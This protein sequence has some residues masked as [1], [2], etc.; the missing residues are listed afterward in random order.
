MTDFTFTSLPLLALA[1]V[2]MLLLV[3]VILRFSAVL[4][5]RRQSKRCPVPS[6]SDS[7]EL[8]S[9]P[10]SFNHQPDTVLLQ[11]LIGTYDLSSSEVVRAHVQKSLRA[12]GVTPI[13]A[14]PGDPFD[15]G[16]HNGV[17][18]VVAPSP[19]LISRIARVRR[20]GWQSD[21][22]V[23]RPADVEVYKDETI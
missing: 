5:I 6:G 2:T 17:A 14:D 1:A 12:V 22:G 20:Q 23:L 11:A 13:P 3:I 15:L 4:L 16:Q 19:E 8:S 18:G 9:S 7:C 21:A 10:G